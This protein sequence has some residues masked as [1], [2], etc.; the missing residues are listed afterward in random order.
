VINTYEPGVHTYVFGGIFYTS[1][2]TLNGKNSSRIPFQTENW[3]PFQTDLMLLNTSMRVREPPRKMRVTISRVWM[4][5]KIQTYNIGGR[6]LNRNMSDWV[7]L[8]W[9]RYEKKN[10]DSQTKHSWISL[11][12]PTNTGLDSFHKFPFFVFCFF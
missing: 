10:K 12:F 1:Q 6:Y 9:L 2:S 7:R 4:K 5:P 8:I 3:I 11:S